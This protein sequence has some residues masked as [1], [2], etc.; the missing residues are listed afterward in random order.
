M[1]IFI[2][3][4][5]QSQVDGLADLQVFIVLRSIELVADVLFYNTLCCRF[6]NLALTQCRP[7]DGKARTFL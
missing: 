1:L 7:R 6:H 4:V 5:S 3:S 2:G